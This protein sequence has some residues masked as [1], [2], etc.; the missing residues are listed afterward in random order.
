M[1]VAIAGVLG[2]FN[3]FILPAGFKTDLPKHHCY[4]PQTFRQIYVPYLPYFCYV[5]SLYIGIVCPVLFMLI[6]RINYDYDKWRLS[7]RTFDQYGFSFIQSGYPTIEGIQEL[8]RYFQ[9]YV[10]LLKAIA[11]RYIPL[12]FAVTLVLLYEQLS[13]SH[14]TVTEPA[15]D[16]GKAVLW[17]LLGP[18]FLICGS[19]FA[20]GYQAAARR[21][22]TAIL[23][24]LEMTKAAPE[25][26]V[27]TEKLLSIR[28]DLL[29]KQSPA[30]FVLAIVKSGSV[31]IPLLIAVTG[32][33]LNSV[34][35]GGWVEV[36]VPA[37]VIHFFQ[38]LSS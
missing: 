37:S 11:E 36:F 22:Q 35:K 24:A 19:V 38:R 28:T 14:N 30:E 32:Y 5:L 4:M 20:F 15:V 16:A 26:N 8:T 6:R 34:H 31:F 7:W 33:I 17:F 9:D 25:R 12:L 29:W 13:P 10:L 18:S 27:L 21:I 1:T 2:T 23:A 3:F